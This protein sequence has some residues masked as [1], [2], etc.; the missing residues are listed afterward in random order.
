MGGNHLAFVGYFLGLSGGTTK[1]NDEGV[2]KEEHRAIIDIQ[3]N[4]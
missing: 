1:L 3:L 4:Q 2:R